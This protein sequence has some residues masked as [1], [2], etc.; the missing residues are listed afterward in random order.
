MPKS[1]DLGDFSTVKLYNAIFPL[2]RRNLPIMLKF[3]YRKDGK[4]YGK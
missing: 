3:Q 4:I 1:M 2:I